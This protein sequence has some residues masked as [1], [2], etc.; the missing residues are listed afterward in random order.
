MAIVS[1]SA[2]A[3]SAAANAIVDLID[4]GPSAGLI[5][6]YSGEMPASPETAVSS[7]TLLATL[8]FSDPAF[9]DAANGIVTASAI[10]EDSAA[11]ANGTATWAR[12]IDS[13]GT[14]IMDVDVG[15][16]GTTIVLNT[17]SVLIGAAVRVTSASFTMPQR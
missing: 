17:T 7:Q 5:N 11:D 14:A 15:L 9:G 4:A 8:A 1:L 16:A 3:R 12:I 13:A 6:I 2:A 10:T